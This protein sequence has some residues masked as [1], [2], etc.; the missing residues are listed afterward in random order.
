MADRSSGIH[1]ATKDRAPIRSQGWRSVGAH[2]T[3]S[4]D[5]ATV[6]ALGELTRLI[7]QLERTAPALFA[8]MRDHM[9]GQPQA[10]HYATAT[11]AED[12]PDF[13]AGL[14]CE[15]HEQTTD[16]CDARALDLLKQRGW[17]EAEWR[18]DRIYE[19]PFCEG[20]AQGTGPS[21]PAGNAALVRDVAAQDL[22]AFRR[23]IGRALDEMRAAMAV[24]SGYPTVA[25]PPP[26][27]DGSPG[28]DLCRSCWRCNSYPKLIELRPGTPTPYYQGLCRWCG[29]TRK[30]LL[31]SRGKQF[32]DQ[33]DP[34]FDPPK[35]IVEL[36]IYPGRVPE[37]E[38][39]KA[40]AEIDAKLDKHIAARQST[41]A[42]SGK[43]KR[44]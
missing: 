6:S 9:N 29:S 3:G 15:A 14:W 30:G 17:S 44:K 13:R 2:H 5:D 1:V 25:T 22:A 31:G 33:S 36:H 38:M 41:A 26:D 39:E 16:R 32:V 10:A 8:A 20:I 4:D 23:H 27:D 11:D 19:L 34:T 12:A 43:K 42:K 24:R 37:S 35:R 21:D 18:A 40:Q 7:P 28:A